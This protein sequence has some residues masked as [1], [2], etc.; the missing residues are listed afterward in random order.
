VGSE[1]GLS[2]EPKRVELVGRGVEAGW[3]LG[4]IF[5]ILG[6]YFGGRREGGAKRRN[7]SLKFHL[8]APHSNIIYIRH[9]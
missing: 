9:G 6:C 3:V 5:V 1:V 7:V 8:M 2:G 4:S